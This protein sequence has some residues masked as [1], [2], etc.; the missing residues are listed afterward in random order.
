MKNLIDYKALKKSHS[1][2]CYLYATKHENCCDVSLEI[3]VN[4]VDSM[5]AFQVV[6]TEDGEKPFTKV[7]ASFKEAVESYNEAK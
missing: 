7:F 3:Y 6:T 1:S 4:P 2:F 5:F